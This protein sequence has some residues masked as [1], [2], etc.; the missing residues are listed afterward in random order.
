M[1]N[2][3][4]QCQFNRAAELGYDVPRGALTKDDCEGWWKAGDNHYWLLRHEGGCCVIWKYSIARCAGC[5]R[6]GEWG[7]AR[8]D[9]KGF[10]GLLFSRCARTKHMKVTLTGVTRFRKKL[11]LAPDSRLSP[12]SSAGLP[13]KGFSNPMYRL[14]AA[15]ASGLGDP[16]ECFGCGAV[17]RHSAFECTDCVIGTCN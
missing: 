3:A 16:D 5:G 1:P 6:R 14:P 10:L 11:N 15:K 7:R 8:A 17:L 12:R 2:C 13:K 9:A 4:G